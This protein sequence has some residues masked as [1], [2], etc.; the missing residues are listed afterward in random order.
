MGDANFVETFGKWDRFDAITTTNPKSYAGTNLWGPDGPNGVEVGLGGV[1]VDS[2]SFV[3]SNN[4]P[5]LEGTSPLGARTLLTLKVT[6]GTLS[7]DEITNVDPLFG[8]DGATLVPEPGT[9]ALMGFV[10][11]GAGLYRSRRRRA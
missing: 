3:S 7:L 6:G 9:W 4:G 11:L 1:N 5:I 2:A 10:L 8:T